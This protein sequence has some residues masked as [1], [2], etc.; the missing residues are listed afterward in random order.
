[1]IPQ[2]IAMRGFL[3]YREE[4][5]ICLGGASLWM[6][7][8]LNGSGKSAVFDAVTYALFGGHRG[9]QAG[10]QA[11]INKQGNS[12][13]VEFEF[14]L[15]NQLYQA[16]RT[17]KLNK[18]GSVAGTQQI[19]RW[20]AGDRDGAG[21]WEAVPDTN[22]KAGFDAW[23][24]SHIG[25][26]YE[27]F[28]SSVLLMQGKAEKL[29]TAA[30]KE[31]FEVLAG[32]VDLDRYQRLHKRIDDRRRTLQARAETLQHQ[33]SGLADVADIEVQ[34]CDWQTEELRAALQGA[35]T[36]LS[37][38][39]RLELLADRWMDLQSKLALT[40]ELALH[41]RQLVDQADAIESESKRLAELQEVLPRLESA[42][43]QSTRLAK[44]TT[45]GQ[46]YEIEL[47]A[48]AQ[49]N[50][51]LEAA[52]EGIKLKQQRQQE[53]SEAQEQRHQ[54]VLEQ[55]HA[56]ALAEV[57]LR[58]LHREREKL[59]ASRKQVAAAR[60][61]LRA[62]EHRLE[63]L[64]IELSGQL[65][66]L[67]ASARLCK[68]VDQEVAAAR[69]LRDEARKRRERFYSVVGEQICRYCG[70]PL[71]LGHVASE[72]TK[73]EQELGT[74]EADYRRALAAQ[75]QA[76]EQERRAKELHRQTERLM[77]ETRER[78]RE[79]R[80]QEQESQR[81]AQ[82]AAENC[83]LAFQELAEPFRLLVASRPECPSI[84]IPAVAASSAVAV[85]CPPEGLR[86]FR[87]SAGQVRSTAASPAPD[88]W[89]ET[90][91]P[92]KSDLSHLEQQRARCEAEA[93]VLQASRERRRFEAL[94]QDERLTHLKDLC[95]ALR[96]QSADIDRQLAEERVR[97]EACREALAAARAI[98][99]HPWSALV[100]DACLTT[101]LT[102]WL[103]E[104]DALLTRGA[105]VRLQELR[106]AQG[107]LESLRLRQK[108][109]EDELEGIP[110][111]A[112]QDPQTVRQLCHEAKQEL[113]V[114]EKCLLKA[115]QAR[116]GLLHR[117]EQ[118][119]SL[120]QEFLKT[121][122]RLQHATLLAG[123]LGRAGL[124]LHLVRQAERTIVG[125]ANAVL[126]RLSGGQLYL[127]LCDEGDEDASAGQALQLEA[128]H[129]T[130]SRT[131][132]AVSFLS[133]SQRFRVAVSLALG[134]GEY[135]SRR[136]RP[137]ESVIID[138]GFGCLDRQGRQVMIQELNNL[139][140]QLR[141]IVLVSHQE[142]FA[143]AFPDGYRFELVHGT[144]VATK[145]QR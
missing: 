6:L 133:G 16:R 28:T 115:E 54:Q 1:M 135:A 70:Q 63:L 125:Y 95:E 23:V 79:L 43:E 3:C 71:T 83:T 39:Q 51:D 48:L 9:G 144:T 129:R 100:D 41:A 131:P 82:P 91:Y 143:D 36:G 21:L 127:R 81:E 134:M 50:R 68:D 49:R 31:R 10:A 138:E 27:T 142:E 69:T 92:S 75:E 107:G 7:A 80:Q 87:G 102:H 26:T 38:L 55:R 119:R 112:R 57:S 12:L 97:Q 111:D 45:A 124:Q 78:I 128:I 66:Q 73:L 139:R 84:V 110:A 123:L 106:Q 89:L 61:K 13:A 126:D 2:R 74:A 101:R 76:V 18:K 59:R 37:Q 118:R 11:L 121:E 145:F 132:I 113:A 32:I 108:E 120:Q 52:Q 47:Q 44:A 130:L 56:L 105:A 58:H 60:A 25:L 14:L 86:L 117:R 53:E 65:E 99:P 35:Q 20:S 85:S 64:E 141:C 4:Q 109:L 72:Q 33:L 90:T 140:G 24:R 34:E 93:A 104:R 42:A 96:R 122:K 88:D 19:R 136:H 15:D 5:E 17:L 98:L 137:I 8:G 46:A 67:E 22:N 62:P 77:T 94:Q 29:L 40:R 114:R 103:A 116:Q 30:P